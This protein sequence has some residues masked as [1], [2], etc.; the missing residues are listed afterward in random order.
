MTYREISRKI[1]DEDS[2]RLVGRN[3][4]RF[5]HEDSGRCNE[6]DERIML[7]LNV[8][9]KVFDIPVKEYDFRSFR[10]FP[11]EHARLHPRFIVANN[12]VPITLGWR[13]V[14]KSSRIRERGNA[15]R[16]QQPATSPAGINDAPRNRIK[17]DAWKLGARSQRLEVS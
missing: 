3:A 15:Q 10:A 16:D 8:A 14:H 17:T 13:R 5:E 6:C 9:R 12:Y 4:A 1:E 2:L 7:D 11:R